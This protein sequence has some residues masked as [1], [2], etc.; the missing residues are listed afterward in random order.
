V[1][2]L[3]GTVTVVHAEGGAPTSLR[4]KDD[5]LEGDRIATGNQALLRVLIGGK[6]VAT[7]RER[8]SVTLE[9]STSGAAVLLTSGRLAYS[10]MRERMRPGEVHA[11]RTPNATVRVRGTIVVVETEPGPV[12]RVC[13]ARGLVTVAPIGGAEVEIGPQ[14]CVSIE[15]NAVKPGPPRQWQAPPRLGDFDIERD[16]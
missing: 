10:V 1:T 16:G 2:T 7:V 4:F 12:S 3:T 13:V 11:I 9:G 15:R 8:T 14:R 6:A 5:V